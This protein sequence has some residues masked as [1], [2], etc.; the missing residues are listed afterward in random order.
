MLAGWISERALDTGLGIRG[1]A[2]LAGLVGLYAGRALWGWTGWSVGPL[3][4][5]FAVVPALAGALA[6][7][8]VLKLVGLGLA[9][10]RR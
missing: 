5:G 2:P 1:I 9:G 6:T 3:V 8:A 4:A 7:C 10:P